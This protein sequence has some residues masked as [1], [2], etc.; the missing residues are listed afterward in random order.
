MRRFYTN[1]TVE[2]RGAAFAVLLDDKPLLTPARF[3]LLAP[4]AAL[5]EG[6]ADEWRRQGEKLAVAA[7]P[8]TQLLN[9]ALDRVPGRRREIVGEIA[10]YGATDLLCY[11][12]THPAELVARQGA[13]W[14]PLLDWL[15]A[16][17]GARLAPGSGIAIVAQDP[18]ALA[19]IDAAV[20]AFDDCPLAALHLATG[21]LGSVVLG[22][23]LAE[24][25]LDARAAHAASLVDESYQIEKWGRDS[26]A[27]ARIDRLYADI[28]SATHFMALSR[29]TR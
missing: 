24:G 26:E 15:A 7:M 11:R 5:A 23:A 9:T 22:L 2:A 6:V 18:A 19:R 17:H 12:A 1:V 20:S 29:A 25:R 21:A 14:N 16:R 28:A 27:A 10:A 3:P 13:A 8:L 4:T